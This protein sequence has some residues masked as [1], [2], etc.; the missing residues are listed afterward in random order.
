MELIIE[1]DAAKVL[2]KMPRSIAENIMKSL[3]AI[4]ENP[5]AHHPGVDVIQG[6]K[7]GFRLR[8]GDW[9]AVYHVSR[10]DKTVRVKTVKTR[11]KVYKQ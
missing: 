8:K 5:F 4:A 7:D 2:R 6:V 10:A 11:G 9:R 3:K 1:K